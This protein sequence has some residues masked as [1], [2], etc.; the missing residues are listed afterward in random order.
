MS[1]RYRIID[2]EDENNFNMHLNQRENV[3][4]NEPNI[5]LFHKQDQCSQ[6]LHSNP[7]YIISDSQSKAQKWN[8]WIG[9]F[10]WLWIIY[11]SLT[12]FGNLLWFLFFE[13]DLY[14]V[15]HSSK[16]EEVEIAK[17]YSVLIHVANFFN[18]VLILIFGLAWRKTWQ[19]PSKDET[20]KLFKISIGVFIFR[21]IFKF[22]GIFIFWTAVKSVLN[23]M[24]QMPNGEGGN[25]HLRNKHTGDN[26]NYNHDELKDQWGEER[27][28]SYIFFTVLA[29]FAFSWICFAA[30]AACVLG[31]VYKYHSAIKEYEISINSSPVNELYFERPNLNTR[32]SNFT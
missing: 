29:V 30:Y 8:Q 15:E 13:K 31:G 24:D 27:R 3:R 2:P 23:E 12:S 4:R 18:D 17:G 28:E 6:N 22:I 21:F 19:N 25:F 16:V 11:G 20:W 7:A 10:A 1:G 9:Y 26:L 32:S 5:Q 14:E